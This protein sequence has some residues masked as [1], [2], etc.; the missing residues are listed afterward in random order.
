M[1]NTKLFHHGASA[2][3]LSQC[4]MLAVFS[5]SITQLAEQC[6]RED[7]RGPTFIRTSVPRCARR[8]GD[9]SNILEDFADRTAYRETPSS[10]APREGF[11][12][13][14]AKGPPCS[15]SREQTDSVLSYFVGLH[16]CGLQPYGYLGDGGVG[17]L[18]HIL[19]RHDQLSSRARARN[20]VGCGWSIGAC[21]FPIAWS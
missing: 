21:E 8:N 20:L 16:G 9:R 10:L 13:T 4:F 18:P 7:N 5:T 11:L 1:E 17:E 14:S 19:F 6:G 3:S 12:R 15:N 2:L